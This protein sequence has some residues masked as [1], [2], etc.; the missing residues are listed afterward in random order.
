MRTYAIGLMLALGIGVGA[1]SLLAGPTQAEPAKDAAKDAPKDAAKEAPKGVARDL[2]QLVLPRE[3]Y[4]KM[5]QQM[6][7]GMAEGMKRGGAPTPKDLPATMLAVVQEA[8]PYDEQIAFMTKLYAS[9]FSEAELKDMLVFYKT[10]TGAKLVRE[11]P[12]IMRESAIWAGQLLPQRLPQLMAKH[13]IGP[14]ANG[15]QP[16]EPA[17]TKK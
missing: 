13:G 3:G 9:R 6:A 8:L 10:P 16:G 12:G 17:S 4:Q 14:Q 5:M 11:L 7:E 15:A 1:S 2:T